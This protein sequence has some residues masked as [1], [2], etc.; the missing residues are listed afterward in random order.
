MLLQLFGQSEKD[1]KAEAKAQTNWALEE[2]SDDDYEP[3]IVDSDYDLE[4]GDDDLSMTIVKPMK[5]R[6]GQEKISERKR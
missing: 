1:T 4:E 5:R 3:A 2:G 6:K